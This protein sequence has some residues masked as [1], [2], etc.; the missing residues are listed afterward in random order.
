MTSN[1]KNPLPK[2][3]LRA[4]LRATNVTVYRDGKALTVK[5]EPG[6][7]YQG[8]E[9]H[10][11]VPR[12]L[13]PLDPT[14]KVSSLKVPDAPAHRRGE[15]RMRHILS[16]PK[17]VGVTVKATL[18]KKHVTKPPEA[19]P[20]APPKK[21]PSTPTV[22]DVKAKEK[23]RLEALYKDVEDMKHAD[24]LALAD[25]EGWGDEVSST[26]KNS[27][28]KRKIRTQITLAIKAL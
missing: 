7:V 21:E 4:G 8:E 5:V 9:F 12:I 6:K 13:V 22:D 23:E 14:V 19:P 18:Q 26:D 25:K 2:F 3:E 17:P 1:E 28:L 20:K 15:R 16:T 11:W 24:L 10:R 27:V